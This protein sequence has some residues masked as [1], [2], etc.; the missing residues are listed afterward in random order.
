MVNL[1]KERDAPGKAPLELPIARSACLESLF[2]LRQLNRK[3]RCNRLTNVGIRCISLAKPGAFVLFLGSDAG[4]PVLP[5]YYR[6]E[7]F[8]VCE[9]ICGSKI[10]ASSAQS[11]KILT[12]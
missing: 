10:A 2:Q 1:P 11:T 8:F 7:S 6:L 9:T 4:M 12:A 3:N 5:N